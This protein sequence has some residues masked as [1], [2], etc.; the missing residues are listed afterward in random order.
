M[1]I[2]QPHDWFTH[3]IVRHCEIRVLLQKQPDHTSGHTPSAG[4]RMY[5]Q[6]PYFLTF[7]QCE[8]HHS[9][10]KPGDIH[11]LITDPVGPSLHGRSDRMKAR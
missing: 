5:C 6:G 4:G 2:D 3:R 7:K 10:I 1:L 8:S 9:G 11:L